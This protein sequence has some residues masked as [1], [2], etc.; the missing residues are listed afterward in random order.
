MIAI[1]PSVKKEILD[2]ISEL[3]ET[4]ALYR[5]LNDIIKTFGPDSVEVNNWLVQFNQC[6]SAMDFILAYEC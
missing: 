4:N 3:A 1:K 6:E 5:R 2:T